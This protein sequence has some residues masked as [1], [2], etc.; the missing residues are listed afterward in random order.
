MDVSEKI[1]L[2][3]ADFPEMSAQQLKRELL[4][5]GFE[6][7]DVSPA[8]TKARPGSRVKYFVDKENAYKSEQ[9]AADVDDGWTSPHGYQPIT[10]QG[11]A[12]V[13]DPDTYVTIDFANKP[14]SEAFKAAEESLRPSQGSAQVNQKLTADD[15]TRAFEKSYPTEEEW[16][17]R[18]HFFE[19][20]AKLPANKHRPDETIE[21]NQQSVGMPWANYRSTFKIS[22]SEI[23]KA[24]NLELSSNFFKQ[25][26]KVDAALVAKEEKSIIST[27]SGEL[28]VRCAEA[29]G[30]DRDQVL[31][32]AI[33]K[34]ID[35][36]SA[37]VGK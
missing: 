14:G 11:A 5:R 13:K 28:L 35:E 2:V 23:P 9:A 34:K 29:Y 7:S 24:A 37:R 17:R 8:V 10:L 16:I 25:A 33:I 27:A 26:Y 21:F 12:P 19:N 32:D 6:E 4:R 30:I 22:E 20:M 15:I 31:R 36:K 3:I 18:N 1:A